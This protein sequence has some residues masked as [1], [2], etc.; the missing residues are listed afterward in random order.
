MKLIGGKRFIFFI[1]IS[2]ALSAQDTTQVSRL[3]LPDGTLDEVRTQISKDKYES[4]R[5][6]PSGVMKEITTFENELP[7]G[8]SKKYFET[9]ELKSSL[10]FYN[11]NHYSFI[12]YRQDGSLKATGEKKNDLPFGLCQDYNNDGKLI[13]RED[14][15]MG[16]PVRVKSANKKWRHQRRKL[17]FRHH[18]KKRKKVILSIDGRHRKRL[19]RNT[20]AYLK[21]KDSDSLYKHCLISGYIKDSVVISKFRYENTASFETLRFDTVFIKSLADIQEVPFLSHKLDP[22]GTLVKYL[23]GFGAIILIDGLVI[24]PIAFGPYPDKT[25]TYILGSTGLAAIFMGGYLGSR[26]I[27]KSYNKVKFRGGSN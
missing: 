2:F 26:S 7:V 18:I 10:I 19:K 15:N 14:F 16:K 6:Y 20:L 24:F 8:V 17:S 9:G 23:V 13:Y 25:T 5:Y 21:F 22:Q 11:L 1:F 3:F 12:D 27:L 4:V